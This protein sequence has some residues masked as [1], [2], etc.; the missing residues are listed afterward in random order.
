MKNRKKRNKILLLLVLLLAVSIGF[1][2]LA[3]TLKINGTANIGKNTWN[4]YWDNIANQTGSTP[5]DG[6]PDITADENNVASSLVTWE[7][8]LDEPGNY[9]EFTVDAVN[10]GTLDA[11][12]TEVVS[13]YG[14]S[15]IPD[16]IDS[17]HPSP[18]PS[19]IKYSVVYA[20]NGEKP[21]VGDRLNKK[22]NNT[23]TRRT[24]KIRV[25]YDR[26]AVTNTIIN[27][28]DDEGETHTFSLSVKYGQAT[29]IASVWTLPQGKT[30]N[31]L[32]LGDELCV[33]DQCFNFVRYDGND[34]VMLAKYNLKV[35]NIDDG[36]STI[37]G[38]T[39]ADSGYGLQSS[40]TRG[41]MPDSNLRKGVVEFSQINYWGGE[42]LDDAYDGVNYAGEPGTN[43]Y[44]VAYY[45]EGYKSKLIND[46]NAVIKDARLLTSPEI[47]GYCIVDEIYCP[48]T[49]VGAFITN[50]SYWLA[51]VGGNVVDQIYSD[52][53]FSNDTYDYDASFGVRPVIV[54]EKSNL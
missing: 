1:A 8:T 37:G 16:V 2:A 5:E 4:I 21:S 13:K 19:Y 50:T 48:T 12:I 22:E 41:L 35:G 15:V 27:E 14:N 23:P 24:Y 32:E 40:E 51:S 3:T 33:E 39:S 10:E 25:E 52:G 30:A 53:V 17:E 6:Y 7:V 47:L 20:D 9:Y 18:V 36:S 44:S 34:V 29:P 28:M 26:D 31:N 49:G 42:T 43:T 11:E 38:Y 46:Y 54:V 45:V